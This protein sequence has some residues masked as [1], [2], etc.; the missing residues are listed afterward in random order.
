MAVSADAGADVEGEGLDG[1]DG[2]GDVL[3]S[4]ASGEEE[5]DGD[6]LADGSAEGPV[7][8]AAGTAELFDG[9]LL[10]AGV[11]EDGVDVRGDGC[12]FFDGFGAGDVDDLDDLDAGESL[13]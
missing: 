9:E 12:G 3:R 13:F 11:E 6:A 5:W 8:G 10:V 2:I 1:G 7:V 4:E